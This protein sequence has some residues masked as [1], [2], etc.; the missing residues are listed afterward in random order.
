M[1]ALV[2]A[3][4]RPREGGGGYRFAAKKRF[5]AKNMRHSRNLEHVPIPKERDML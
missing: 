3:N 2:P 5:A 4:A 1:L